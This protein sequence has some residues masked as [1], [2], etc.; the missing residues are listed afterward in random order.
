MTCTWQDL[1]VVS[2]VMYS[3]WKEREDRWK[4][5]WRP[6]R[7][8]NKW[9]QHLRVLTAFRKFS[10]GCDGALDENDEPLK[11]G[12]KRRGNPLIDPKVVDGFGVKFESNCICITYSSEIKLKEVY[13]GSLENDVSSKISDVAAFVGV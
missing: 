11:V 13:G 2:V 12:L 3:G 7:G 9:Q 5:G 8:A 6:S 1:I 10:Q 4:S